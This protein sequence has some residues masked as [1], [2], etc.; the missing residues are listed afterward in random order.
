MQKIQELKSARQTYYADADWT[1]H[2]DHLSID[3]VV[4]EVIRGY[5]YSIRS[6]KDG[7]RTADSDITCVV[8]T[9]LKSYPIFVG[10]GLLD[11]LGEKMLHIGRLNNA[12]IISDDNV[13]AIYGETARKSLESAGFTVSCFTV[14]PSKNI[15][16]A[17]E[18]YDFLI[19]RRIARDNVIIALGGGVVGDLA[20]FVAA[21][22]L[23][24]IPWVQVPTSLIGIVDA[25]IGGKV[26]V[27]HTSG[28]NL[29]GAFYQP[30][31][32]LADVQTLTTL[33]QRELISGWA[34]VIKHGL[35]LDADFFNM[36][37]G[38]MEELKSLKPDITNQVIARSACIKARVVSEDE[39]DDAGKRITLNYGHTV[40]HGLETASGYGT[41]L[42]GE[43]VSL[44]MMAAAKLSHRL[45]LLEEDSVRRQQS[46]LEKFG[47]P[48]SCTG[49]RLDDVLVSMEVDKK[50]RNKSIQWVLLKG[51]GEAVVRGDIPRSDVV[52][53]LEEVMK[54]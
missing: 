20:G 49:L 45:G 8:E 35:V 9:A 46:I 30:M 4:S 12:V 34:E 3:E 19:E 28:K 18:I 7:A 41:F 54:T 25:S 53:V 51:I 52:N 5:N 39:R 42:H 40:A 21:T 27:D 23:R 47:L 24:G 48:V 29:I 38:N 37:E 50:V 31:F 43:A 15:K 1:V 10:W 32:V 16:Q 2:T 36:I 44:G 22:Y 33:P 14:V 6:V 26:A 13:F 17:I 11:K